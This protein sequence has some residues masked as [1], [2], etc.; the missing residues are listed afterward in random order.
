MPKKLFIYII[1]FFSSASSY[2]S[3]LKDKDD[4]ESLYLSALTHF[5]RIC[6]SSDSRIYQQHRR[7]LLNS[8]FP[9]IYDIPQ[10]SSHLPVT[11]TSLEIFNIKGLQASLQLTNQK[12]QAKCSLVFEGLD[13]QDAE[14][15]EDLMERNYN[16]Y[17]QNIGQ[18]KTHKYWQYL[19]RNRDLSIMSLYPVN[20]E[21]K[22]KVLELARNFEILPVRSDG[23]LYKD[24]LQTYMRSEDHMAA[25]SLHLFAAAPYWKNWVS[26]MER[27]P[28]ITKAEAEN[29]NNLKLYLV[30]RQPQFEVRLIKG[31]TTDTAITLLNSNEYNIEKIKEV[32]IKR[33][34][35]YFDNLEE[36]SI[37]KGEYAAWRGF[38]ENMTQDILMEKQA[39][40]SQFTITFSTKLEK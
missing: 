34:P 14:L 31:K 30:S 9:I 32:Y 26:Q 25:F 10:F 4:K 40:K 8:D 24:D 37:K 20:N 33:L 36:L 23:P 18:D 38:R 6:F 21:N 35:L 5:M 29:I 12:E 2:G 22:S 15:M 7:A 11:T 39:N 16:I 19:Q 1:L 17:L 3:G 27:I 28:L 13:Y